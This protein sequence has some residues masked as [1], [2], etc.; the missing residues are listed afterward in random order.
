M[1]TSIYLNNKDPEKALTCWPDDVTLYHLHSTCNAP[2]LVD[3][4][5]PP[6]PPIG[7]KGGPK[8]RHVSAVTPVKTF[9]C[10]QNIYEISESASKNRIKIMG[11]PVGP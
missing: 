5:G 8:Y 3:L 10:F 7:C 4:L 6:Q 9:V 11:P 2:L 1:Y